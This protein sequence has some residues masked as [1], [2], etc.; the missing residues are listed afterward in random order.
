MCL[1]HLQLGFCPKPKTKNLGVRNFSYFN[2]ASLASLGGKYI[3]TQP[4]NWWVQLVTKKYLKHKY[5]S[6]VNGKTSNLTAWKGILN[7]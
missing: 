3:L 6:K 7:T 1:V 2:V 4:G 5:F